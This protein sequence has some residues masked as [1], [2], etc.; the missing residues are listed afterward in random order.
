MKSEL[1]KRMDRFDSVMCEYQRANRRT[2][3]YISERVGCDPSSLWRYRNRE[4][5]FQKMPYCVLCGCLRL[6]NVSNSDLRYICGLPT[7]TAYE[8]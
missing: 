4:D 6:A 7:G 3:D 1:Y 5:S 2:V 8:K